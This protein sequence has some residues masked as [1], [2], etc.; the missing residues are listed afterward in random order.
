MKK[1]RIAVAIIFVIVFV[2]VYYLAGYGIGKYDLVKV[3]DTSTFNNDIKCGLELRK[4]RIK[5]IITLEADNKIFN[6]AISSVNWFTDRY[7]SLRHKPVKVL[8]GFNDYVIKPENVEIF[9]IHIT[10]VIELNIKD[11]A[12]QC[13]AN[14]AGMASDEIEVNY[15]GG[16]LYD[17]LKNRVPSVAGINKE[18]LN[19]LVKKNISP[20]KEG[21]LRDVYEKIRK[22]YPQL[23]VMA[24]TFILACAMMGLSDPNESIDKISPYLSGIEVL[25]GFEY[26][27]IIIVVKEML[28]KVL[29]E[30]LAYADGKIRFREVLDGSIRSLRKIFIESSE[31]CASEVIDRIIIQIP[32]ILRSKKIIIELSEGAL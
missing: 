9:V 31:K 24:E 18:L 5:E 28:I 27:T 32:E 25:A 1:R 22:K 12:A 15:R 21:E 16:T 14:A 3:C 2:S 8:E 30:E 6:H 4:L 10:R 19:E 29:K 17:Y 11:A 26:Q 23:D 20:K 7:Y 13:I